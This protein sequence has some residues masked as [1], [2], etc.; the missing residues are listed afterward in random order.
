MGWHDSPTDYPPRELCSWQNRFD[1]PERDYRTLYCANTIVTCMR[2]VL[3]D[4]RPNAVARADFARWQIDQ[5]VP[6]EALAEPARRVTMRWREEHVLVAVELDRD[7]PLADIDDVSLRSELER[8]HGGLLREHGMAH[9]D[10]SEVRSKSRP[11]TQ[12]ISRDLFDHGAAGL[13]FGSNLDDGR[14]A[15]AFEGRCTLE[16]TADPVPLSEDLPELLQVCREY[17][18]LL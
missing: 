13:I 2:E 7:G 3:A 5:G 8:A 16:A 4:L 9:L 15:V 14:C 17:G 6:A 18:L 12:A 1:D 11:V 10:I